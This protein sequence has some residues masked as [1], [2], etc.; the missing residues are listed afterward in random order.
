MT[1]MKWSTWRACSWQPGDVPCMRLA[2]RC[3]LID[4]CSCACCYGISGAAGHP[5]SPWLGAAAV[6]LWGRSPAIALAASSLMARARATA[7]SNSSEQQQRATAAATAASNSS[8]QQQQAT[9]ASNRSGTSCTSS[10]IVLN[11]QLPARS[12]LQPAARQVGHP[13]LSRQR[14]GDVGHFAQEAGRW[15]GLA[16]RLIWRR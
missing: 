15:T 2:A 8:K 11:L 12:G 6:R 9:A 16:G 10:R 13:A 7:A 14:G 5:A 1:Y 3:S 4:H